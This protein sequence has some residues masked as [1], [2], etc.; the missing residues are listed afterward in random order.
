MKTMI[1]GL[2]IVLVFGVGYWTYRQYK[3]AHDTT[4]Q[5]LAINQT[6]RDSISV[7]L[8]D[9]SVKQDTINKLKKEMDR[10]RQVANRPSV[11]H[12]DTTVDSTV[13]NTY[14]DTLNCKQ[15]IDTL[16]QALRIADIIIID[17]DSTIAH[18]TA[19][20]TFVVP[21][22]VTVDS[23]VKSN[24]PSVRMVAVLVGVGVLIGMV[25]SK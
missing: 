5:V 2:L 24:R 6:I 13:I 8:Q 12:T 20:L 23:L 7:A 25:A 11:I 10:L 17:Q 9:A 1:M 19:T 22:T 4:N 18:L 14:I 15:T 21:Q 16:Q 3:N